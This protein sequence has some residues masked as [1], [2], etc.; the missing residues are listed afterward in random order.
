M[1][2]FFVN[3]KKRNTYIPI[4]YIIT[5]LFPFGFLFR[6]GS[7]FFYSYLYIYSIF[8]TY[9][10]LP[11]FFYYYYSFLFVNVSPAADRYFGGFIQ[12]VVR[13]WVCMCVCVCAGVVF[14]EP[15]LTLLSSP[16]S[17]SHCG[18]IEIRQ[19]RLAVSAFRFCRWIEIFFIILVYF[20]WESIK[21]SVYPTLYNTSV[22]MLLSPG[23]LFPQQW[24]NTTTAVACY[25]LMLF[26]GAVS[27]YYIYSENSKRMCSGYC[28]GKKNESLAVQNISFFEFNLYH[29]TTILI[30]NGCM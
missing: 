27:S 2:Y 9:N 7:N 3:N 30:L 8:Y 29:R 18:T 26:S 13:E 11:P 12:T 21:F 1:V 17:A 10:L 15:L 5:E 25:L 16:G 19:I 20:L 28:R 4:I 6:Q 23:T 24:N 22:S 14:L